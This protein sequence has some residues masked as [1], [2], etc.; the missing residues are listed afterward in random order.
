MPQGLKRDTGDA[1]RAALAPH[2]ERGDLP[3]LVALLA[4]GDDV[5]SCALGYM[6][7]G[8]SRR[9]ARDTIFRIASV[10]KPL[11]GA[12][13]MLLIQDGALRLS[14]PVARWIPELAEP[15]V[16][17]SLESDLD[18]TIPAARSITVEDVLSFRLGWG[19]IMAPPGTYPIQRAEEE[20]GLRTFGPPWPPPDLTPDEWISRL[21]DLPLL[22]QPGAEWRYNTGAQVA[23][24][25][26]ERVA[27]APLEDVL[28]ERLFDPLG[29][30]DT[31][32]HVPAD[33]RD[34]FATQYSPDPATGEPR[35]LDPPEGWWSTPPKMP[36]AAGWLVSTMDDLSRFAAMMAAG[37]DPLLLPESIREMTRDRMTA[38]DRAAN[39]IFIG[40]A[41]GWGLMMAAPAAGARP[42]HSITGG[43]GWEG[44]TGTSWRFN[45]GTGLTAII[46][47]QRAMT[48]PDPPAILTDFW[49]AA[50]AAVDDPRP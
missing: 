32:F 41:G 46:L 11:V 30:V 19:S 18:D 10:S 15:R 25:L 13:A 27:G 50:D 42:S 2:V 28:R 45:P 38:A 12:V 17:R 40:G 37:G 8:E 49:A 3:G 36:N 48:S 16:L 7:F 4:C 35:L 29:M 39:Q 22:H 26:I 33:R 21:A 5:E 34:R 47:T 44:G 43:F 1:L 24:V 31:G 20:L 23:G 9:M 6:G 14:D